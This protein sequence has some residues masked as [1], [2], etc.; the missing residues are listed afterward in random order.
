M[1]WRTATEADIPLLASMNVRLIE[2][3]G[4]RNPMNIRQLEARMLKWLAEE[5]TAILFEVYGTPVGY[6]LFIPAD[7]GRDGEGIYLRQFFVERELRRRGMGRTA[8]DILRNE[9]WHKGARVTLDTLVHNHV[10]Q[11][12]FKS[13][14]FRQY[15]MKLGLCSA[16]KNVSK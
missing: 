6:A 11:G 13:V 3:E 1:Q 10:A 9:I 4:H 15:C 7:D 12:F 8:I 2:D 16:D 5:Y 14:G